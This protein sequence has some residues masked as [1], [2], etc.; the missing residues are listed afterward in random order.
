MNVRKKRNLAGILIA[1]LVACS[2]LLNLPIFGA[3]AETSSIILGD[4][5][6]DGRVTSMDARLALRSASKGE[7]SETETIKSILLDVPD[8][9]EGNALLAADVDSNGKIQAKDA[10]MILRFAA[11]II[12]KL[13][14]PDNTEPTT[15]EPTTAEPTTAEPT[16]K[17]PET[18]EPTTN[19]PETTAPITTE[20]P[21]TDP[22]FVVDTVHA[23]AGDKN[24]AV[25]IAVKNNP[26]VANI[27]LHP[28]FDNNNLK[29]ADYAV[30]KEI[31]GTAL[32]FDP[33]NVGDL[34]WNS[35]F[36]NTYGD[37]I[38]ATVYF[39]ISDSA[40]GEYKIAVTY[41]EDNVFRADGIE[42]ENVLFET[43]DGAII[44]DS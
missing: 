16:T 36:D 42:A 12:S 35:G 11:R 29:I 14:E 25:T 21:S 19:A 33:A 30:N 43:I 20:A 44:I 2:M 27:V 22:A 40:V 6:G 24:V 13:P 37:W 8:V 18:T 23:H 10:R 3:A 9:L 7:E 32:P 15:A 39:D 17:A 4:V 41:D 1:I 28:D 31:G 5:N 34:N 26:G 38:F